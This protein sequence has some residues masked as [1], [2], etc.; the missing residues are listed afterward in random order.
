MRLEKMVLR[1]QKDAALPPCP[2]EGLKK[3]DLIARL[4]DL[5]LPNTGKKEALIGRLRDN[6][7]PPPATE[8][9]VWYEKAVG[10]QTARGCLVAFLR[11]YFLA[12]YGDLITEKI[13]IV[14]R[15]HPS[16]DTPL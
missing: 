5:N 9:V 6:I 15:V 2:S 12:F 8:A 4:K 1:F 3:P 13:G 16:S 7:S 11:R 10:V 14:K